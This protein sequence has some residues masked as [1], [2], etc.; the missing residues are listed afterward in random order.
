MGT[1][2]LILLIL[3]SVAMIVAYLWILVCAFTKNIL[4]GLGILFFGPL[5]I[6]YA[7]LYWHDLKKPLIIWGLGF[8][9]FVCG[10]LIAAGSAPRRPQPWD[11]EP[12]HEEF[13]SGFDDYGETNE[14]F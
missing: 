4:W 3:A 5:A 12:A 7:I 2:A 10:M 6:A 14:N 8:F 11:R 9:V 13:D 1:I